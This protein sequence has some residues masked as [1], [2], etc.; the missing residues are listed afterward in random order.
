M[1]EDRFQGEGG[2]REE[3]CEQGECEHLCQEGEVRRGQPSL[4]LSSSCPTPPSPSQAGQPWAWGRAGVE[5]FTESLLAAERRRGAGLPAASHTSPAAAFSA[6]PR[7][8]RVPPA[9]LAG[10]RKSNMSFHL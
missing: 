5:G 2:V 1:G 4:E 7:I 8:L 6:A 10:F 9:G 3:L